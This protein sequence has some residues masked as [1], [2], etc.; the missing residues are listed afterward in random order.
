MPTFCGLLVAA[1]VYLWL[2]TIE[3]RSGNEKKEVLYRS[4]MLRCAEEK[5][6]MQRAHNATTDSIL[7]AELRKTENQIK[8]MDKIIKQIKQ[9]R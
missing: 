8:E 3:V 1:V 5:I 4:E 7:R 9:R 2:D 6:A